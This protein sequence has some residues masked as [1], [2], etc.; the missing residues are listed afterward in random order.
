MVEFS[1]SGQEKIIQGRVGEEKSE[2]TRMIFTGTL[3]EDLMATV[4]RAERLRERSIRIG[5]IEMASNQASFLG[6]SMTGSEPSPNHSWFASVEQS[7][8]YDS[9]C[10]GVA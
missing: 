9:K 7:A 5:A 2:Q 8:N 10:I 6:N 1:P 4:E 3:I